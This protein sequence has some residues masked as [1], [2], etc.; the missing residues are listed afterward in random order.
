MFFEKHCSET[1]VF[2]SGHIIEKKLVLQIEISL[3]NKC[4]M[5]LMGDK[6]NHLIYDQL[7]NSQ[8]LRNAKTVESDI[9]MT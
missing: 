7:V 4:G 5:H 3:G 9:F 2:L 8:H 6:N 1:I